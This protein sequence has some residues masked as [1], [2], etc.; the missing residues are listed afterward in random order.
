MDARHVAQLLGGN[1]IGRNEVLAPGPRH[2]RK[3]RSLSIKLDASAPDGFLVFSHAGDDWKEC[4]DYVRQQLGLPLWHPG[5]AQDRR[6]NGRQVGS[7]DRVA[8]KREFEEGPCAWTEEDIRRINF[9]RSIWRDG[10]DPRG[11]LA[12]VYLKRDRELDLDDGLAGSVLRFHPSCP[13][14]DDDTGQ[15]IQVPALVAAFRSVDN[16][17]ITAIQRVRLN[18]DGSKHSRRMLGVVERAAIMLGKPDEGELT[19]GEGVETVMAAVQL[20][21]KPAWALG[22][23]GSIM[24]FPVIAGIKRLTL[25]GENDTASACAIKICGERWMRAGCAVR[26]AQPDANNKDFNDELRVARTSR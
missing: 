10:K 20:G 24:R 12:E 5:H 11:T 7:F 4:R 6:M 17:T 13:W 2:S 16:S 14:G 1:A 9:G 8:V 25:L 26:I 23:C 19:I 21:F 15:I 3:D 18:P 22:S